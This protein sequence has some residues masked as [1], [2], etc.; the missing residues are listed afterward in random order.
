[1]SFFLAYIA[2]DLKSKRREFRQNLDLYGLNFHFVLLPYFST[3]AFPILSS[4]FPQIEKNTQYLCRRALT[5]RSH[6]NAHAYKC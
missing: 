6:Y 1:M 3:T 5:P 2:Q 4:L